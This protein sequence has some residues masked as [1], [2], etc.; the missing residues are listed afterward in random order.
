MANIMAEF[1]ND[2]ILL[3]ADTN[4][5]FV[6][7]ITFSDRVSVGDGRRSEIVIDSEALMTLTT[8]F[9]GGSFSW[10]RYYSG[11]GK[12]L[13]VH[14]GN[15]NIYSAEVVL[16]AQRVPS[17]VQR[18]NLTPPAD[19]RFSCFVYS[20]IV[21]ARRSRNKGWYVRWTVISL[22]ACLFFVPL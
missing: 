6:R 3:P 16:E 10:S 19:L 4:D 14:V 2:D 12:T 11:T 17:R 22:Y 20:G 8:C 13:T 21:C 7:H 5:R 18:T 15:I 9:C 1:G